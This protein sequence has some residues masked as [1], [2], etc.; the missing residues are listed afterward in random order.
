[1][2]DSV[3]ILTFFDFMYRMGR[4]YP[5]WHGLRCG[6]HIVFRFEDA[7]R[8][9][10]HQHRIFFSSRR[11]ALPRDSRRDDIAEHDIDIVALIEVAQF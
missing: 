9:A 2:A 7:R 1:M 11:S 3:S 8:A 6:T 5:S 4:H 10:I